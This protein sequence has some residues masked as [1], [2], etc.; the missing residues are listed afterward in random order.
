MGNKLNDL[1]NMEISMSEI[2]CAVMQ[3]VKETRH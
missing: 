3:A 1:T 2:K